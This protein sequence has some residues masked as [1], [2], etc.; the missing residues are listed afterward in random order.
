MEQ[1]RQ[2]ESVDQLTLC[3]YIDIDLQLFL[4]L[5][6]NEFM[7]K[8]Q[9]WGNI[10]NLNFKHLAARLLRH[11]GRRG[12]PIVFTMPPW[13]STRIYAAATRG[14][15]KSAYKYQDFLH[16]E[17]VDM[18]LCCQW[19]VLPYDLIKDLPGL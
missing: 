9:G 15:H 10:G 12:L 11:I 1:P 3:K 19:I 4:S 5:R 13:D 18:I 16:E 14:P 17:M 2:Q 6:W 8:H 7:H